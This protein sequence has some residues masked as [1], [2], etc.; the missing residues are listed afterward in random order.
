MSEK[1][2]GKSVEENAKSIAEDQKKQQLEM[3]KVRGGGDAE[4]GRLMREE[5]A[6][7]QKEHQL[8]KQIEKQKDDV[9]N[10]TVG[11]RILK[12]SKEEQ[13]KDRKKLESLEKE[14]AELR[15]SKEKE[16]SAPVTVVDA[17]SITTDNSSKPQMSSGTNVR[18]NHPMTR[19]I[20][21]AN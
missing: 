11:F 4:K 16:K 14:I 7:S 13:E 19:L 9:F 5:R 2:V 8:A 20:E 12:E 1:D 15:A 21:S 10:R 18:N 3:D 17:K 6:F